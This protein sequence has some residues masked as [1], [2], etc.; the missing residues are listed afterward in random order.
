MFSLRQ[1]SNT[2]VRN[3]LEPCRGEKTPV[4]NDDSMFKFLPASKLLTAM[5]GLLLFT[6]CFSDDDPTVAEENTECAITAFELAK[7]SRS[8]K[9]TTKDGRDSTYTL[10][11]TASNYPFTIDQERNLIYNPDSL[12]YNTT[13]NKVVLG[14]FKALGYALIV[15]PKT[16]KTVALSSKDSLD[17]TTPRTF[18]VTGEDGKTKRNY[19][20]EVRVH[21]EDGDQVRWK[22]LDAAAWAQEGFL[23][24]DV[25]RQ[26]VLG[27]TYFLDTTEG[28]SLRSQ[29]A[30][31]TQ[32]DEIKLTSIDSEGAFDAFSAA[33][34]PTR[35]NPDVSEILLYGTHAGKASLYKQY[36][37][38]TGK[39]LQDWMLLPTTRDNAYPV[40]VL[41]QARLL[42]YDDGFLLVGLNANQTVELRYSVDRGRTW[43]LHDTLRLPTTIGK[44]AQLEAYVN[45]RGQLWLRLEGKTHWRAHLNR[46]AW[47][48]HQHIFYHAPKR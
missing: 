33:T 21:R 2:K 46:L 34:L 1:T 17:F 14:N 12:P 6:A 24:I 23:P 31:G 13:L 39:P 22:Q 43:K 20:V 45:A 42:P 44:T 27:R 30:A 4:K 32:R 3:A 35:S 16:G 15:D 36:V 41:T 8:I 26:E 28:W 38:A 7:L 29:D 18:V 5:S 10:S 19:T 48:K 40:P 9:T 47:T 37:D 11:V 25:R